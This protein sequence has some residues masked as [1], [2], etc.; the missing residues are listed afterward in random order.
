[1]ETVKTFSQQKKKNVRTRFN[2]NFYILGIQIQYLS[3]RTY[4]ILVLNYN[5]PQVH[6]LQRGQFT[7]HN[8]WIQI[9]Y[10]KW[11]ICQ[12][13][14]S[15]FNRNSIAIVISGSGIQFLLKFC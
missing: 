7:A 1:M 2:F 9:L 4:Q 10:P 15:N 3:S 5:C 8:D 14:V 13:P 6:A 12:G 11:H